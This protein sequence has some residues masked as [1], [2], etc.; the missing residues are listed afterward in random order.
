MN[1]QTV[2]ITA[3]DLGWWLG[4]IWGVWR[5]SQ[6][7]GNPMWSANF[8]PVIKS[9]VTC[10][11]VWTIRKLYKAITIR[12]HVSLTQVFTSYG[13]QALCSPGHPELWPSSSCTFFFCSSSPSINTDYVIKTYIHKTGISN[14]FSDSRKCSVSAEF[15][16]QTPYF[17]AMSPSRPKNTGLPQELPS[18]DCLTLPA[19][20]GDPECSSN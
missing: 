7:S 16:S 1:A 3:V 18:P 11:L 5:V 15:D 20:L 8:P 13:L 19:E 9:M 17:G 10:S 2:W 4:G 6:Q 12:L 14:C